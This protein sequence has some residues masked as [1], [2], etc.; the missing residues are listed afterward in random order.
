[1]KSKIIAAVFTLVVLCLTADVWSFH[2][3]KVT[4]FTTAPQGTELTLSYRKKLN[5]NLLILKQKVR[6]DGKVSF[7]LKG[8][9]VSWFKIDLPENTVQKT[10]FRGWA[11]KKIALS[12]NEYAGEQLRGRISVIWFKFLIIG[13]LAFWTAMGTIG[14]YQNRNVPKEPEKL[15]KMMNL[16]FLRIMFTFAVVWTH[17]ADTF[18]IWNAGWLGV[19]FFFILSGFLL[20]LTFKPERTV[21]SF[22]KNKWIRFAP[23]TL[24][25]GLLYLVLENKI[26]SIRFFSD[27]FFY[28]RSGIYNNDGYNPPAWYL[29][30]LMIASVFYFYMMQTLKKEIANLIISIVSFFAAVYISNYGYNIK[31]VINGWLMRGVACIGLGYFLAEIYN[32]LKDKTVIHQ[33]TYNLLEYGVFVFATLNIFIHSWCAGGVVVCIAF[34]ALILMFAM[35]KGAVSNFFEKTVF[36]KIAKYCLAIYLTHYVICRR[37][38]NLLIA[39]HG[40]WIL[41]H[42]AVSIAGVLLSV[43]ALGVFAHHAIEKPATKALKE[44]LG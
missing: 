36:A 38:L 5:S 19:E 13:V 6:A 30:V 20:V 23:L 25:G 21:V 17:F 41:S 40:D 8:R 11:K 39:K 12:G 43:V 9:T 33:K 2:K 22:I 24:F 15:P 1:M 29:S 35:R 10:V 3:V 14:V 16:E 42:S 18:K 34:M 31:G 7:N 4:F 26:S 32:L 44:W 28:S 37:I 27:V